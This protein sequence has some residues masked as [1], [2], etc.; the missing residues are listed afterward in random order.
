M[1]LFAWGA[2]S[3]GQLGV[4][5][6]SEFELPQK[7]ENLPENIKSISAGAGH[8]IICDDF[9]DLWVTGWNNKG[10][11]GVGSTTDKCR[12]EKLEF[13]Q[14]FSS[15][16]AGWDNSAG[17]TFSNRL[18]VWGS[19]LQGQLG[20]SNKLHKIITHPVELKFPSDELV[21]SISFGLRHTAVLTLNNRIYIIGSLKHFKN[22]KHRIIN[23]NSTEFMLVV[24]CGK[25]RE[26][27]SGQ[28]HITLLDDDRNSICGIGDNKFMQCSEVKSCGKIIKLSS[29]WTHNAFLTDAKELF[30]YGRNSYGQLGN[31][32]KGDCSAVPQKCQIQSVDEF[33]LGAEHG[34]LLSKNDIY[35]WGWNEH[36]NCGN[37]TV[38]DV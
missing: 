31:G 18:F 26:L 35:T 1:E 33:Q 21:A 9:G 6:F 15:V 30:L 7:V 34:I 12:F 16:S 17:I 27:A 36:G 3:H 38:E 10:Q 28:N 25:I 4:G 13:H 32:S 23:H 14:K 20:F 22:A 24:P 11:L 37:G 5:N 19:N 8:T 2:N 29:G